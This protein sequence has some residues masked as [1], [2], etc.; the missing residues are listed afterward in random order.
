MQTDGR[1]VHNV[2]AHTQGDMSRDMCRGSSLYWS[3]VFVRIF[4]ANSSDKLNL[5][6][7]DVDTT[8]GYCLHSVSYSSEF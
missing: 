3:T 6:Q 1:I 5:R 2:A 7:L 8:I 4:S